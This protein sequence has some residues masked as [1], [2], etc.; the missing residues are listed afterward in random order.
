[1]C[2][3]VYKNINKNKNICL[4]PKTI[5]WIYRNKC[6]KIFLNGEGRKEFKK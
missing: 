4:I 2:V 5:K 6:G 3:C 1:M